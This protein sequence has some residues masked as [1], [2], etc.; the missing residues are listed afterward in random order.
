MLE[1]DAGVTEDQYSI[2]AIYCKNDKG[3]ITPSCEGHFWIYPNPGVDVNAMEKVALAYC[4][5][6]SYYGSAEICYEK[7]VA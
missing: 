3:E 2:E 4:K 1:E 6:T 7:E 5:Q